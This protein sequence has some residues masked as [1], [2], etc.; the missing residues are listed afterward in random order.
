[1]VRGRSEAVVA[2]RAWRYA[3]ESEMTCPMEGRDIIFAVPE[4]DEHFTITR[5][6]SLA[7]TVF[8]T[9]RRQCPPFRT[10]KCH[11]VLPAKLLAKPRDHIKSCQQLRRAPATLL[12]ARLNGRNSAL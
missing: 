3:L 12:A 4:D 5:G 7:Y 11:Q 10:A 6:G 1:V 8:S 2:Q 9:G